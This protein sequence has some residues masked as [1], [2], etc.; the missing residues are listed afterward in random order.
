MSIAITDLNHLAACIQ[1]SSLAFWLCQLPA[2]PVGQN[3]LT[4]LISLKDLTISVSEISCVKG[5]TQLTSFHLRRSDHSVDEVLTSLAGCSQLQE[6]E[7]CFPD[8]E[9]GPEHVVKSE[10]VQRI[11]AISSQ[12]RSLSFCHMVDQQQFDVLLT[13]G[14][15][16]TSLTCGSLDLEEDRSQSACSLKS[17]TLV[18]PDGGHSAQF[19]ANMPLHSVERSLQ[20]ATTA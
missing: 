9:M 1:L 17:V 14:T 10:H 3:P 11:I 5:L 16:L 6:L 7:L 19:L 13:H 2:L 15:Q 12:L 18:G 8:Y 4:A 20:A